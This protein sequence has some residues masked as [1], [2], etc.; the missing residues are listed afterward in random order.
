VAVFV[1]S[2]C[3]LH[4]Y[5]DTTGDTMIFR[6]V[7]KPTV[8]AIERHRPNLSGFWMALTAVDCYAEVVEL[9]WT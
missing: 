8:T 7:P 2:L 6:S 3:L 5:A 4:T 1:N 9:W